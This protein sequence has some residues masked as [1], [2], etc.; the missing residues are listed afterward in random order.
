MLV[1][2]EPLDYVQKLVIV[3]TE[4][5]D[6]VN[7]VALADTFRAATTLDQLFTICA[8][9]WSPCRVR[10]LVEEAKTSRGYVQMR[11]LP[12]AEEGPEQISADLHGHMT[13]DLT[14]KFETSIVIG[15]VSPQVL[16]HVQLIT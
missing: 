12:I 3:I 13:R 11:C 9:S 15:Q 8:L 10:F 6:K 5:L 4:C 7:H 14:F 2:R 16:H 1:E